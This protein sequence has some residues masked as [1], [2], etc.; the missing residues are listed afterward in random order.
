MGEI[1]AYITE[2][3]DLY[4]PVPGQVFVLFYDTLLDQTVRAAIHDQDVVSLPRVWLDGM[5]LAERSPDATTSAS[6]T[7]FPMLDANVGLPCDLLDEFRDE[8]DLGVALY[9]HRQ[10]THG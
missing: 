5:D 4:V 3:N 8:D 9:E 10:F 2:T 7:N 6:A 1:W